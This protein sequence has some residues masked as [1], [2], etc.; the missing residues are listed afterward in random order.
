MLLVAIGI[1]LRMLKENKENGVK[2]QL[3]HT[4][5]EV[6][7][8]VHMFVVDD[9]DHLKMIEIHAELQRLSRLMQDATYV[10]AL[11][12]ILFCRM[13]KKKK[14]CSICVSIARNWLLHLG[15]STQLLVHFSK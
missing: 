5:I 13:L 6:N 3:G 15:S 11:Y 1:F 2:E 14:G 4:W 10:C 8:E 7:N 12:E 9:Q